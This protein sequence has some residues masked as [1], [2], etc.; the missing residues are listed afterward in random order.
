MKDTTYLLKHIDEFVNEAM[1]KIA[2]KKYRKA[3]KICK[4]EI[5][6]FYNEYSP[7]VYR[8]KYDLRNVYNLD[9]TKDGEFIFEFGHEFMQKQHRVSNEYIYDEM[10]KEGWHGGANK[11]PGHP[12]PGKNY[13]RTPSVN[14]DEYGI[15]AYSYWWSIPAAK[16]SSPYN[17]IINKWNLY[18]RSEGK[19]MELDTWASTTKKYLTR[20]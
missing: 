2:W 17:N 15:K 4:K 5:D 8:R 10:F 11:G 19:K 3:E 12:D 16:S 20:R 6:R 7:M 18:M 1:M 9:V 14:D 13:W